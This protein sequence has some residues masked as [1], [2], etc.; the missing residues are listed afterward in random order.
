M[1]INYIVNK[2]YRKSGMFGRILKGTSR[3]VKS[4]VYLTYGRPN[5]EYCSMVW[6]K[7]P[8]RLEKKIAMVQRR[9]ARF[10]FGNFDRFSSVTS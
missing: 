3:E 9:A 7:H 1:H 4:K 8:Q 5:L 2:A 10:V 6:D